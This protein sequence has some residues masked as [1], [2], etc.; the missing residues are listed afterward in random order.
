MKAFL[1][2]VL[3]GLLSAGTAAGSWVWGADPHAPVRGLPGQPGWAAAVAATAP[4]RVAPD[5]GAAGP[6]AVARF[7]A[8]LTPAQRTAL[9]RR[10]PGVVGN[11]DGAPISLRYQANEQARGGAMGWGG[12][13]LGYDPRGDGRIIQVFGDLAAARHIAVLV[14]G[15]GWRLDN[16]ASLTGPTGANPVVNARSLRAEIRRL[17][18]R[19]SVALVVW[20]GYDPPEQLDRQAFRSERATAGAPALAR[21]LAGLPARAGVSLICHSYGAVV[22]GRAAP[23][24][25]IDDLVALAAP[26]MDVGSAADLQSTARVWAA[27]T[28]RDPIRFV[29]EVRVGPL[30]HGRN[31]T[32]PRFGARVIDTGTAQ[33]H[34]VY[35]DAGTESVTNLARIV[36]G[37]HEEVTLR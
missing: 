15:S 25:P 10:A 21:F 35:S 20:L 22:C 8:A 12:R 11:L 1:T 17:D 30:G 18:P 4:G 33:G 5:P 3:G 9:A 13:L 32:D 19:A 2:L 24:A 26:G 31:P 27:R 7:F 16:L 23:H 28:G 34:D 6:A 37:R 14:P 36:L 29:P